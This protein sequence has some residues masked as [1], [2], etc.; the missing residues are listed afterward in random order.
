MKFFWDRRPTPRFGETGFAIVADPKVVYY[1]LIKRRRWNGIKKS[2]MYEGLVLK[3]T[4][5]GIL[6]VCAGGKSH[7]YD[8]SALIRIRGL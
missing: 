4:N 7:L 8:E 5:D 6:Q 2:W 1:L 3:V